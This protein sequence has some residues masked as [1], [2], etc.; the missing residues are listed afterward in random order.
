MK[1]IL[2]VLA[3]FTVSLAAASTSTRLSCNVVRL[4]ETSV[5]TVVDVN[6]NCAASDTMRV[7]TLD[8]GIV[9]FEC[10]RVGNQVD[11][12]VHLPVKGVVLSSGRSV[13]VAAGS[14]FSSYYATVDDVVMVN[15]RN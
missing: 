7:S 15:C 5:Y 1:Y 11:V 12:L 6:L 2:F 3:S 13:A 8:Y 14:G 4:T 10:A 9:A